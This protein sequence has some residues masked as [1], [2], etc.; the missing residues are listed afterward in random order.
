M[1]IGKVF[2]F[3]DPDNQPH[4]ELFDYLAGVEV[5]LPDSTPSLDS[6]RDEFKKLSGVEVRI[7]GKTLGSEEGRQIRIAMGEILGY[8]REAN[9]V[10]HGW[11]VR[12]G[13]NGVWAEWQP[14]RFGDGVEGEY[15]VAIA[16]L[17]A[18]A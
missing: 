8:E 4:D 1:P 7:G 9:C 11:D 13:K 18:T 10:S 14:I 6:Y 16:G 17:T 5:N 15:R 3:T 12:Y 2:D